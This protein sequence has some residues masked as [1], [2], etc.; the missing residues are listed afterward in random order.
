M[1][2][3]RSIFEKNFKKRKKLNFEKKKNFLRIW[4]I[5]VVLCVFVLVCNVILFSYF[6]FKA[7]FRLSKAFLVHLWYSCSFLSRKCLIWLKNGQIFNWVYVFSIR[8]MF[9]LCVDMQILWF[10]VFFIFVI[11]LFFFYIYF[12]FVL[13]VFFIS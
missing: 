11:F 4:E 5:C 8:C 10:V 2:C 13:F 12:L 1:W 9:W 3:K 6:H 7:L